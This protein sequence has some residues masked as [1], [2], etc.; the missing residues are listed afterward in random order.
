MDKSCVTCITYLP[1][2][3][4]CG[5]RTVYR[6]GKG[7]EV[8]E[9]KK[10]KNSIRVET[11]GAAFAGD[12]ARGAQVSRCDLKGHGVTHPV[13]SGG[14]AVPDFAAVVDGRQVKLSD[15]PVT[16]EYGRNDEQCFVFTTKGRL[17]DAFQVEQ[18]FDVFR[19]G[20]VFCDFGIVLDEG[21]TARVRDAVMRFPLDILS[22]RKF[23]AGYISRDPQPKQDVT[24]I[25]IIP[26]CRINMG[27]DEHVELDH[28]AADYGVNL[29]WEEARYFSHRLEMVIED[30]TSLGDEML[31]S[32]RTEAGPRDGAW[33]LRWHVCQDA[34]KALRGPF[35]YRNRW[36]LL[37]GAARTEAGEGADPARR[38]NVMGARVCHV[39]YPYV[40]PGDEW[41]RASMPLRQVFYQD[42]QVATGN[43]GLE[44]IDEAAALGVDTLILHQFWMTNSGSNGE[45][46]AE[47]RAHD[48]AWLKAF[49]DYAHGKGMRVAPYTRGT[50]RYMMFSDFF[51]E[52]FTRDLDGLYVDWGSPFTL[53][54]CKTTRMHASTYDWFMFARAMRNRV[55]ERGFII[56]HSA[57]PSYMADGIMDS[58]L[59]GEF[60]VLHSAL[61][62]SPE[63]SAGY[64]MHGACGVNLIAG[65][66]PDRLVFSSQR[67]AGFAAGLGY[68]THPF[69]ELGK[70]FKDCCAY[71]QPLWDLWRALGSRPVRLFNPAVG[72]L[73]VMTWSDEALHPIAYQAA[74]GTTLVT[75]TNLGEGKVSGT[76]EL[77]LAALGLPASAKLEPLPVKGTHPCTAEGFRIGVKD[78]PPF[79]F[80]GALIHP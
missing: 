58:L 76:V 50:E 68:G 72:T 80:C 10:G 4:A 16:V 34:E 56:S 78:M 5:D 29:G 15:T 65:N 33:E 49:V 37:A 48:P 43:P 23:R 79:F 6:T 71:I 62:D 47:Y 55:G 3:M 67:S 32:T 12:L 51:E 45:P 57:I 53:G 7:R 44:R 60:S 2:G 28:L 69:M 20:V 13:L 41:P 38:N 25:H 77:D 18:R 52:F 17:G 63:R 9:V 61:L 8:L 64:A 26:G 22:A 36:V 40:R 73:P 74:D 54:F 19:E 75:V 27:P 46:M 24:C 30:S 35:L 59:S 14:T 66:A 21:K 42:A 31:G 1:P 70:P 11:G 39:I